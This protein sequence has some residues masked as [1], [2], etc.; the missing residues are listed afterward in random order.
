MFVHLTLPASIDDPHMLQHRSKVGMFLVFGENFVELLLVN[1][2]K[3]VLGGQSNIGISQAPLHDVYN[4]A[5]FT[6]LSQ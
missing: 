6:K 4:W 5:D 3:V 1:D 2:V